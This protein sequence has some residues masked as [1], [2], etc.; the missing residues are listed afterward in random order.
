MSGLYPGSY[1]LRPSALRSISRD[2]FLR[3]N[4]KPSS[5]KAAPLAKALMKV[6]QRLTE[7]RPV[8]VQELQVLENEE[9]SEE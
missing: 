7:T 1:N 8:L 3:D 9:K 5:G 6:R 2:E 4:H